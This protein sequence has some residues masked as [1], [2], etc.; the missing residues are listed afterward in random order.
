MKQILTFITTALLALLA[1]LHATDQVTKAPTTGDV[2]DVRLVR[3]ADEEPRASLLG[4][5]SIALWK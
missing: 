3:T 4:Q 1:P 2:R 5:P